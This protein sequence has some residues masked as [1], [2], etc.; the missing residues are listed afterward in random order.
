MAEYLISIQLQLA[1]NEAYEL[2]KASLEK[3]YFKPPNS[4]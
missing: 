4:V 3:E 1:R 2:L